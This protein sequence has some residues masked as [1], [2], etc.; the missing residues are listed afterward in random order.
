MSCL[1]EGQPGAGLVRVRRVLGRPLQPALRQELVRAAV[2]GRVAVHVRH[3]HLRA[4][5]QATI[6]HLAGPAVLPMQQATTLSS[7]A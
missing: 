3:G 6:M 2:H 1:A 4:P 5:D 7:S